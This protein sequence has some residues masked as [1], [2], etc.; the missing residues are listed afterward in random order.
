[1][2]TGFE[3]SLRNRKNYQRLIFV[4]DKSFVGGR[5][6]VCKNYS[7]E[8]W[9]ERLQRRV[10]LKCKNIPPFTP[11]LRKNTWGLQERGKA[12]VNTGPSLFK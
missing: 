5:L 11:A 10:E 1:M 9:N 4:K 2:L 12:V 8:E 3:K 7:D 6:I